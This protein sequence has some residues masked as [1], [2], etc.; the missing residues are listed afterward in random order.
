MIHKLNL[1][2]DPFNS[3][4]SG[5]KTIEMRLFDER[6]QLICAGDHIIF[7]N[8][9]QPNLLLEVLVINLYRYPSF[10]ELYKHHDKA[11]IGYLNGEVSDPKDM[12]EYYTPENIKK[13]GVVGIEVKLI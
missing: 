3:I 11:S 12:E 8:T 4:K 2:P 7:I 13:Y 6:R 1:N 9:V 10:Y 5:Q